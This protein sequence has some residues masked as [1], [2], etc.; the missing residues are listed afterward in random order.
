MDASLIRWLRSTLEPEMNTRLRTIMP[1][2]AV[3]LLFLSV[4]GTLWALSNL[5]AIAQV[6]IFTT[7]GVVISVL[8][9]LLAVLLARLSFARNH[10]QELPRNEAS[11]LAEAE[12]A[13]QREMTYWLPDYSG[14]V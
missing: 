2:V 1:I 13:L 8:A 4:A 3:L 14:G 6:L 9:A 10:H 12:V 7:V 11:P 5:M